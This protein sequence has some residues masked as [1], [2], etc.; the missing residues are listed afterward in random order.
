M[1]IRLFWDKSIVF[2]SKKNAGNWSNIS[3]K[4]MVA[5]FEKHGYEKNKFK[6]SSD[7]VTFN[8]QKQFLGI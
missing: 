8:E 6:V 2:L 4:K 3:K 5:H 7:D 1:K